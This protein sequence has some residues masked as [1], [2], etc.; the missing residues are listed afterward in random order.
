MMKEILCCSILAYAIGIVQPCAA[1]EPDAGDGKV[2]FTKIGCFECHGYVGQGGAAG[3]RIAPMALP[4]EFVIRYVRR[5]TGE[6]PAYSEKVVSDQQMAD[7]YAYLKSIPAPKNIKD[8]PL[9]TQMKTAGEAPADRA[10][11]H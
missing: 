7:I 6:M 3:A 10:P 9:L 11:S 1:A 2:L 5:P 8:I 4:I